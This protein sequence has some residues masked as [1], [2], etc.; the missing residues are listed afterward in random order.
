MQKIKMKGTKSQN[1]IKFINLV[2]FL[3]A[4]LIIGISFRWQIVEGE[5]FS[6]IMKKRVFS[7]EL[8]S[9]RGAIYFYEGATMAYSEPRY[10]LYVWLGDL[11]FFEKRQIQ[12]REEFISKVSKVIGISEVELS[13]K[14]T[15]AAENNL[16]WFQIGKSLTKEQFD[17][18][19]SLK[20][21]KFKSQPLSGF[22]LDAVPVRI[23]PEKRLA[24][25]VV[26]LT[27]YV[28]KRHIGVA[29][30]EASYNGVLNPIKGFLKAEKDAIGQT[31]ASSLA[32]TI[33][34]KTGASVYTTIRK[35]LQ[36]IIEVK[37]K[38]G[39]EKY[40]A[41]SGSVVVMDPK[42]GE[43]LSLANYP[44]YD[45]NFIKQ[46][47]VIGLTNSAIIKPYEAGS[48][49]KL[50]TVAAGVD[51][52][53][54]GS[55]DIVLA[56]GHNGCESVLPDLPPLC[57][58]DKKPQPP[59]S[60]KDCFAKSDN[61]CFYHMARKINR[62]DFYDYM[63]AF[64]IG[65]SSKIDIGFGDSFGLLKDSSEWNLGDVAAYSYGHGYQVNALQALSYTA[66]IAN[67]G[68]RVLPRAVYKVVRS[69][70]VK[71]EMNPIVENRVVSVET[72]KKVTDMMRYNF[73][74][75]IAGNEYQYFHL[76]KYDLGVKSGTALI[77]E[78]GSYTDD[79]N[80]SFVGF[81]ASPERTFAM[82]VWLEKPKVPKGDLLAY[83]NARP[84]WLDIFDSIREILRVPKKM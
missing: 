7:T 67:H 38:E 72:A 25:H 82:I 57:T 62:K 4:L 46:E 69:N 11:E 27:N 59:M 60:V 22:I 19:N 33:E 80:A 44:D 14:F 79:M 68:V 28:D 29:G 76:K 48:I 21:D 34:P 35:R 63:T 45:P 61:V 78:N 37:L 9:Q 15:K 40:Q 70:G 65:S 3:V 36:E 41:K 66:T 32:L 17:A 47:D 56:E 13:A 1:S 43:I 26:G 81:D 42:N 31:V 20:T 54:F 53:I 30:I 23:Y 83:Y 73:K 58:W 51:L 2:F 71:V 49:G 64:G 84:L 55:E 16:K 8:D 5:K 50:I 24:S 52:G 10:D 75:A 12:S 39:V 77:A 6:E 18:L 74:F